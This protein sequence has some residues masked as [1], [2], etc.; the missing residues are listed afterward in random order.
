[1]IPDLSWAAGGLVVAGAFGTFM[2]YLLFGLLAL[3]VTAALDK[4]IGKEKALLAYTG[5]IVLFTM[6][7]YGGGAEKTP[8]VSSGREDKVRADALD[9][10][11]D[12]F[13]HPDLMRASY[14]GVGGRRNMYRRSTDTSALPAPEL[15]APSWLPLPL[16]MP[17]TVPGPA[18]GARWV[19]RAPKPV[20]D[21]ADGAAIAPVP[22]TVFEERA[23]QPDEVYDW[24]ESPS[25]KMYV[26]AL[27]VNDG[28]GWVREG[29][30]GY[31]ELI[32][33]LATAPDSERER[34]ELRFALVG[35]A[36]QAAQQLDPAA[37]LKARRGNV[38][39]RRLNPTNESFRRRLTVDNRLR[40][41]VERSGL[42]W[43]TWRTAQDI[44]A[45]RRAADM[46][47][48][49]GAT[50][51]EGGLGWSYAA[52][53]R[54]AALREAD[55]VGDVNRR[56]DILLELLV[57][58]RAR[59]EEAALF[60]VLAAY[61][62]SAP[63]RPDGWTWTG[64]LVLDRMGEA[65]EALRY[66]ERA[67]EIRA[68]H[69][70]AILGAARAHAWMG[71]HAQA[72]A[73]LEKAGANDLEAQLLRAKALLRLGRLDKA[74]STI[75]ALLVREP[76]NA[77]AVHVR[78]CVLYAL[79]DLAAARSAFEQAATMPGGA[80]VRAQACYGLG[81]TTVRLGQGQA[82][83]AAFEACERA[84]SQ[85]S[86][87]GDVP[88][89]TVSPS[90]GRAFL[91]WCEG[92]GSVLGESLQRAREEAP[93]SSYVEM[94]AGMTATLDSSYASALRALS[95]A[96]DRAPSY[97]EL[98]GWFGRVHMALGESAAATGAD[99]G[100]YG[101]SFDRAV[102]FLARAADREEARDKKAY[103][104][105]LRQA[106]AQAA[107]TSVPRKSRFLGVKNT[108]NRI[109][110]RDDLREQPA[111]LCLRGY[112]WFELGAYDEEAY[113]ECI[114]DFQQVV[115]TVP[116]SPD[117]AWAAWRA[118]AAARLTDVKRWRSLEEKRVAF[119]GVALGKDWDQVQ[120][121]DV[122]IKIDEGRLVMKGAKAKRDG[123]LDDPIVAASTSSLFN[124]RSFEE[125]SF[126]IR[127]PGEINGRYLNNN[128]FG[129]QLAVS[130]RG[131]GRG[132]AT[133]AGIGIFNDRGRIA[134]R[135]GGGREDAWKDGEV[136][137][138]LDGSNQELTWPTT[139][140]VVV[141]IVREDAEE[142][143]YVVYLNDEEVLR[144]RIGGLKRA[145]GDLVLWFGG[146]STQAQPYDVE[147]TELRVI[148]Q[149][150]DA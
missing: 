49:V 30:K 33:R 59:H 105:R 20:M 31:D 127:L 108:V 1:M 28:S 7:V 85:G 134:V 58:Y 70:E 83:R 129:V 67:L 118:Y 23:A 18:P 101:E 141:R 136:H 109:L 74:R 114:R 89:E 48:E 5:V 27:A 22:D 99:E 38:T 135:V 120:G 60:R 90:F 54:E 149:K 117:H 138:L 79:G 145:G 61:V 32:W 3:P 17:P 73:T 122:S 121:N 116:S 39:E 92:D 51:Q 82:A 104:M 128:V 150:G 107:A 56:S 62:E 131:G 35:G 81:L 42:R 77:Q 95:K 11:G 57:A 46:M 16:A 69:T 91:A 87:L 140:T 34:L 111:A 124:K 139:D 88:D 144:D 24:I 53:L 148:R 12:P 94:F 123:R 6:F 112:A 50:G 146:Y 26:Y 97:A 103:A 137:R 25:G 113:D 142:G 40:T 9:L 37:V 100:E 64:D 29:E 45:L 76:A 13:A 71:Q 80:A 86:S 36:K 106:L 4:A 63:L 147:I 8:P 21:P 143:T 102:A 14:P 98:D 19:L 96:L 110:S 43:A 78:G 72:L 65:A 68:G 2:L 55:R 125:V 41:A 52:E 119:E 93:R 44:G 115:D 75:E 10:K 84:L 126:R 130:S 66:Y 133:S 47:A 132:R 15:E